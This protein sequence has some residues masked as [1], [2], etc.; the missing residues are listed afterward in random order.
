MK[1]KKNAHSVFEWVKKF[2]NALFILPAILSGA[3]AQ[4][5]QGVPKPQN[6]DPV[7][8]DSLSDLIIYIILPAVLIVTY[9][10]IL[11]RRRKKRQQE[12]QESNEWEKKHRP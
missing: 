2:R 8:L 9:L 4:I 10:F 3:M 12:D 6:N 11:Y 1:L 5:P 7:A